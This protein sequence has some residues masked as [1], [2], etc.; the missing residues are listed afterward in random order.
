MEIVNVKK[1]QYVVE[2]L[3]HK[4]EFASVFLVTYKKKH[5]I[6]RKYS[7]FTCYSEAINQ[8]QKLVESGINVSKLLKKDKF[9]Y[10]LLFRYIEGTNCASV[11]AREDIND[12]YFK[13]LFLIYRFCRTSKIDLDY[14][15]ENFVFYKKYLYYTSLKSFE[16]NDQTSLENYGLYYWLPSKKG[17]SHL[18]EIGYEV[19][20]KREISN[21]ET[22]K[23]IVLISIK[24]W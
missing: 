10:T 1:R 15:P 19:D 5:F 18:K 20:F 2:K 21:A 23:K 22:N 9:N 16:K 3:L 14:F 17:L 11:L 8:Y 6:I 4:D 13:A 7:D 12:E 24:H